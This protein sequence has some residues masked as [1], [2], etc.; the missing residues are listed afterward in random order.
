MIRTDDTRLLNEQITHRQ[1]DRLAAALDTHREHVVVHQVPI[2]QELHGLWPTKRSTLPKDIPK[3]PH[4]I[5]E[6]L[7]I[8]VVEEVFEARH[9]ESWRE[10]FVAGEWLPLLNHNLADI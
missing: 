7:V 8:G 3:I 1:I 5:V 2:K 4:S 6:F 10:Q 9:R